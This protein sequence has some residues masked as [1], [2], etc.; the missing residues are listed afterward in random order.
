[1][2]DTTAKHFHPVAIVVDFELERGLG[3]RK[4]LVNPA[5]LN[6]TKEVIA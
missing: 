6:R 2:D 5:L 4:I 3:E 1:M